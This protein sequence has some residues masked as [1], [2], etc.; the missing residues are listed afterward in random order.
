MQ[1]FLT[2]LWGAK[3][4]AIFDVW[5]VEHILSGVSIGSMVKKNHHRVFTRMFQRNDHHSWYFSL[6]SVLFLAFAWEAVEHYLETGLAGEAVAYWLQ[7]VEF[8]ANRLISDP[9]MLV[10]GY[11]IAKAYPSMVL[12]ARIGSIT[13]L[14]V[15]IFVF[16][17]SMYL[18]TFL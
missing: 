12:P 4:L 2:V 9:L 1:E 17:H 18:H 10:I 11:C 16:P 7:G 5:T 13:W 8:W 6:I 3:T 14:M 15:H